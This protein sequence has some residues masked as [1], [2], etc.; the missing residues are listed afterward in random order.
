MR[1]FIRSPYWRT[2]DFVAGWLS[3][4]IASL[5]L[6]APHIGVWEGRLNPVAALTITHIE[7]IDDGTRVRIW[8][9]LQK[10]RDCDVVGLEW[11]QGAPHRSAY[12][13]FTSETGA[14]ARPPGASTFGPFIVH[15]TE[16]QFAGSSAVA[17]HACG[18]PWDTETT[19]WNGQRTGADP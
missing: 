18:W 12:A 8:G 6:A 9:A 15:L 7:P 13:S 11:W 16:A 5:A 14:T 19:I 3:L 17:K 10:T 1:E 4:L 2:V